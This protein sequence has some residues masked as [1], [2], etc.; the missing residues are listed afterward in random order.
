VGASA[1]G[2]RAM[3]DL[4]IRLGL[5]LA[6]G[7]ALAFLAHYVDPF[8]RNKQDIEALGVKVLGEIPKSK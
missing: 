4:P 8:V 5:G 1:P 6:V 3:L 2:L 7:V